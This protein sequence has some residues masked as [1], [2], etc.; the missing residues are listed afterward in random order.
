MSGAAASAGGGGVLDSRQRS[1]GSRLQIGPYS[2]IRQIGRGGMGTVYEVRHPEIP[3]SLALKVVRSDILDEVTSQR[4]RREGEALAAIAHPNVV[5]VHQLETFDQQLVLVTEFVAGASLRERL[6]EQGPLAPERAREV[7]LGIASA[8]AQ[9]HER[10]VIH[11]DL[12]P[13]NVL[14]RQDG[15]P[16][17][18]DFG[19]ARHTQEGSSLTQTGEILGTP[20]FMAPEQ[21][22]DASSADPRSDVYALGAILF[23]CLAGHPPFQGATTLET[24]DRVLHSPPEWPKS[25][26]EWPGGLRQLCSAALSKDPADRPKDASEFMSALQDES[27]GPLRK[28]WVLIG[29]GLLVVGAL[30]ALALP[31]LGAG[32]DPEGQQPTEAIRLGQAPLPAS[33]LGPEASPELQCW[34][35]VQRL[36]RGEVPLPELEVL[37]EGGSPGAH[38]LGAA[39]AAIKGDRLEVERRLAQ[40]GEVRRPELRLLP[41]LAEAHQGTVSGREARLAQRLLKAHPALAQLSELRGLGALS[42]REKEPLASADLED[43]QLPVWAREGLLLSAISEPFDEPTLER[44]GRA[45]AW[46]TTPIKSGLLERVATQIRQLAPRPGQEGFG[47]EQLRLLTRAIDTF[48]LLAPYPAEVPEGDALVTFLLSSGGG[49]LAGGSGRR[50]AEDFDYALALADALPDNAVVQGAAGQSV[51]TVHLASPLRWRR[52]LGIAWREL[53]LLNQE[54]ARTSPADGGEKLRIQVRQRIFRLLIGLQEALPPAERDPK[55]LQTARE[56]SLALR[57]T[58]PKYEAHSH[59]VDLLYV[60]FLAGSLSAEELAQVPEN[61]HTTRLALMRF[62]F[63]SPQD[64]VKETPDL[65]NKRLVQAKREATPGILMHRVIADYLWPPEGTRAEDLAT[66]VSVI[67]VAAK[68]LQTRNPRLALHWRIQATR[69]VLAGSA[70]RAAARCTALAS[71]AHQL[72]LREVADSLLEFARDPTDE[73][74]RALAERTQGEEP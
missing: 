37:A 27:R 16:V 25:S 11:R 36:L 7:L 13:D 59:Q 10:G 66:A 31:Q 68:A 46:A 38:A 22:C 14:L 21:A 43:P 69:L 1:E 58:D 67:E 8:V 40:H 5:S 60:R 50:T 72:G 63:L 4:F 30:G 61:S 51:W 44:I 35:G 48:R 71:F 29:A 17:V 26:E 65:F 45:A 70:E 73:D 12:K 42:V 3:R 6:H 33:S 18:I 2:V 49:T 47:P 39:L 9:L 64:R 62:V 23:A 55:A 56:I 32:V 19:L 52:L 15:T 20:A 41:G 53:A 34:S 57:R 28:T 54:V 24:L 74:L